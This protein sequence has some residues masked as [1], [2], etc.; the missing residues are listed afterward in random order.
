MQLELDHPEWT[1]LEG[2]VSEGFH[3]K[4]VLLVGVGGGSYFAELL[5]RHGPWRLIAVDPDVVEAENLSRTAYRVGDVKNVL[6]KRFGTS[7]QLVNAQA[8]MNALRMLRP[9][10]VKEEPVVEEAA[11]MEAPIP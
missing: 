4:C 11:E 6:S 1:R 9:R 10:K 5:A 3:N 7:N 2:I 8:A